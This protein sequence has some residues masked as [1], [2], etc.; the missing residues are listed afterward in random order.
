MA[1][2]SQL[3]RQIST[4]SHFT[5]TNVIGK[6]RGSFSRSQIC[7]A[8]I[9]KHLQPCV[10]HNLRNPARGY[11]ARLL[12]GNHDFRSLHCTRGSDLGTC[13]RN[14]V[15]P[16]ISEQFRTLQ[17]RS[18]RK[19][20]GL[21]DRRDD[22]QLDDRRENLGDQ[23]Q[24]RE[25]HPTASSSLCNRCSCFNLD[26]ILS[27]S[28][29][30]KRSYFASTRHVAMLGNS[31]QPWLGPDCT[32]CRLFDTIKPPAY[33]SR[34]DG[35]QRDEFHLHAVSSRVRIDCDDCED[36]AL[37]PSNFLMIASSSKL[38]TASDR[39]ESKE[40]AR[41]RQ[42]AFI[43]RHEE[44]LRPMLTPISQGLRYDMIERWMSSCEKH[45]SRQCQRDPVRAFAPPALIDCAN[46]R[47]V[48]M[49]PKTTYA[50]LSYV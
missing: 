36:E 29:L 35:W 42:S 31:L 33:S 26:K 37:Q 39:P 20:L 5:I 32:L 41:L 11:V 25:H 28:Y 48:N 16:K 13:F 19:T 9:T 47:T 30:K 14:L 2:M 8:E 27:R 6:Q 23:G 40:I 17:L 21:H 1:V 18:R 44:S 49:P 7:R 12:D 38:Y 43:Y 50:A 15:M 45:H 10:R 34:K 46:R 22:L 4:L 3:H 24:D